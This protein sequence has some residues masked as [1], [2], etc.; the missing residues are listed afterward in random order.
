MQIVGSF[1]FCVCSGGVYDHI[2]VLS[3]VNCIQHLVIRI[4]GFVL[5][6]HRVIVCVRACSI[7]TWDVIP[8]RAGF[9][10]SYRAVMGVA[11]GLHRHRHSRC[12]SAY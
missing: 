6:N 11:G 8:L 12:V 10:I 7:L 3:L 2:L 9:S 4:L 5:H 1:A